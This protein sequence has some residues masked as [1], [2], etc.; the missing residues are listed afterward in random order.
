V[1]VGDTVILDGSGSSDAD[2]DPLT[3]TW[4]FSSVPT[5]SGAMLDTTNSMYPT[6]I[7]DVAG[8]YVAQLI[9]SDGSVDSTPD[10]AVVNV[11]APPVSTLVI[12]NAEW[13]A[14]NNT[15][16][17]QGEG[18][19]RKESVVVTDAD[20]G[21]EVRTATAVDG[22]RWKLRVK[23]PASVP[24]RVQAQWQSDTVEESVVSAPGCPGAL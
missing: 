10:T 2:G 13:N 17:V 16:V 11:S 19:A 22:G 5:G 20:T 15:L 21:V 18:A 6:F 9:V 14:K 24:C 1:L 3:Y 12:T 7:A 23:N 8:S 4:S